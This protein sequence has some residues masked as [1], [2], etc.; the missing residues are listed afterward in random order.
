MSM[1]S[2]A[3]IQVPSTFTLAQN[4]QI[5]ELALVKAQADQKRAQADLKTV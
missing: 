3:I 1:P 2:S 4:S 5:F